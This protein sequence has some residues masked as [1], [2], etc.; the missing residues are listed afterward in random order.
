[1]MESQY[2]YQGKRSHGIDIAQ[3][4]RVDKQ[5]LTMRNINVGKKAKA[6]VIGEGGTKTIAKN[7]E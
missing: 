1:M 4:E 5:A 3:Q 2:Y 7:K 6:I